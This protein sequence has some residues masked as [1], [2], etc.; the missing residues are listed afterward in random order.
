MRGQ[1]YQYCKDQHGCR[2]LQKKLEEEKEDQTAL[3]F[4]ETKVY[5]VELMQDPFGNYLCQKLLEFVT[6]DQRTELIMN[7]ADDMVKIALN[8]HGTRALQKMI[9]HITLR[10]QIDA[11]IAALGDQVVNLIQDLNGNHVIQ[12]CLN[13]LNSEE[14]QFIFDAVG[15]HCI[16]VGTHRHGC[17]VLQRCIDHASGNQ[18]ANLVRQITA[19]A[20]ALVQDPFGNYVVQYI[21][22]LG[23]PA[24]AQPLCMGFRGSLGTLSKQKFSSNVIEK[25]IRVADPETKRIMIEEI[26]SPSELSKMANDSFANYVVQ[27]AIEYADEATKTRLMDELKA[28]VPQI[29]NTPHGRRFMQKI[30]EYDTTIGGAQ[31]NSP[32]DISGPVTPTYH[33]R[34]SLSQASGFSNPAGNYNQFNA[35]GSPTANIA[36]PQPHRLSNP[37]MTPQFQAA[38][39]QQQQH[40]R[41]GGYPSYGRNGPPAGLGFF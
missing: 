28:I 8:Q 39:N 29:R 14:A 37:T 15:T 35:F 11:I 27:T 9:E 36:S 12:K 26:M 40:H 22:D 17:C 13:H 30:Q 2:F 18:K 20:F 16:V 6:P 3:I 23:E 7:A 21:L 31:M 25:C 38:M 34:N 32:Q 19:N 4:E 5:V 33:H 10:E 41:Q 1:I 24:F